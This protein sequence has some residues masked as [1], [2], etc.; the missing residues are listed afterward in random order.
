MDD[1]IIIGAGPAGLTAAIYLARFHLSIRL[2]DS[3]SSRAAMIPCTHN[4]AGYPEGIAGKDL[5]GLMLAQ[6]EKYG[7]RREEK[8]VT[9][10]EPDGDPLGAW[11]ASIASLRALP[12]D[13]L[14]LPGHG[15]PFRG[16]H[17]RL[18][19]IEAEHRSRLDALAVHLAE[20]ARARDC[21]PILFRR[22]IGEDMLGMATGE[23]LAHLHHLRIQGRAV[24]E[25]RD[26]VWWWRAA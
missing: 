11:L 1:C 13:L 18:D 16:L 14:V 25:T 9:A 23:A 7:A 6:A 2:F 8:K 20:P 26:G 17:P 21:F 15:A 12:A 24:R 4:H 22:P 19:A 3:G 5:L 10:I